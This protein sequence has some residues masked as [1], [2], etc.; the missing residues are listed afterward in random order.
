[1]PYKKSRARVEFENEAG[2]LLALSRKISYNKVQLDYQHKNLIY[3]SAIVLLSS[4]IEEYLR[5][6]M[7]DLFHNYRIKGAT[8]S[9]IPEN[10]RTYSLFINQKHH[11][12]QFIF[13]KNESKILNDL[14]ISNPLYGVVD[15]NALYDDHVTAIGILDGKKYPSPENVKALYNRIGIKDIFHSIRVGSP[16]DYR[17]VLAS[18]LDIRQTIAHQQSINLTFIDI[19]RNFT[20]IHELINKLDRALYFHICRT[21]G[22]TFWG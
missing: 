17:L 8:L 9:K 13:Q 6:V 1:M 11:F 10:A 15:G 22:Q 3:Q 2:N 12:E 4:A 16:T 5:N 7:E 14:K 18:F 19:K 20:H 21:S